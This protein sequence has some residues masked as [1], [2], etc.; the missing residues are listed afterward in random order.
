MNW[1]KKK[2]AFLHQ[3]QIRQKKNKYDKKVDKLC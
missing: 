3:K 1:E 2:Q